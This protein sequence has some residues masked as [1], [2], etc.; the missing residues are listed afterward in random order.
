MFLRTVMCGHSAYDWNTIPT[1]RLSGGMFTRLAASNAVV[2]PKAIRPALG[3]S[4][5]ARQRST[6][7][8]PHPLGPR[9]MRNSP[10]SMC[11]LRSST[12]LVGGLPWKCFTKPSIVR[13]DTRTSP[14]EGATGHRTGGL[15]EHRVP[16]GLVGGH[17]VGR[18]LA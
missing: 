14:G 4:S 15:L 7:V 18:Q 8:F 13:R 2:S 11:R 6:V 16:L 10:S 9:R 3:V 12:A 5:P 1:L 17:H